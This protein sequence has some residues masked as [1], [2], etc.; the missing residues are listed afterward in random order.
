MIIDQ[1]MTRR[2]DNIAHILPW[3]SVGG[4]EL[5]TLRLARAVAP[6]YQSKVFCLQDATKVSKLFSDQGFETV[7]YQPIV[8][9][10]RHLTRFLRESYALA[11]EFKRHE[12]DI[13]HCSDILAAYYAAVAGRMANLPVLSHVRCR[14]E[15]IRRRDANFLRAVNKFIFVSQD[16]WRT[17]GYDVSAHRGRVIY[18][19]IDIPGPAR[20]ADVGREKRAVLAEFG[21]PETTRIIGMVA[22]VA[23]TKDFETLA[24]AAARLAPTHPDVRFMIVGDNSLEAVHREHY[25]EIRAV[26]TSLGLESR[27]VF[28]GFRADV[29]R[30]IAALDMFVLSTHVEGFPLVILEALAH[31]KPVVATAVGGIP[32]II[33]NDVTGLLSPP[34]DEFALAAKMEA[35]L[36]FEELACRLGAAGRE[37]VER[38]FSSERFAANMLNLCDRVTDAKSAARSR[39]TREAR[40]TLHA[41]KTMTS[42]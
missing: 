31:A 29:S 22:R 27:F 20:G 10:Y 6:R 12:I 19:G 33:V 41:Q 36:Q 23:P 25:E 17:F 5:A 26:L 40:G 39:S 15:E 28:T 14:H 18:D 37:S 42:E 4:T 21:L 3:P 7:S 11:Q 38:N 2:R 24:K 9:S 8:P 16:T 13:V 32:E 1:D 34:R 30:L 35:V